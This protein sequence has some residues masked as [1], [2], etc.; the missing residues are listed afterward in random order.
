M[1]W[2]K[3]WT[4]HKFIIFLQGIKVGINKS[5][6]CRAEIVEVE[7]VTEVNVSPGTYSTRYNVLQQR[8]S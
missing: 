8:I 4:Q 3:I 1:I 6:F 7:A 2:I 5:K